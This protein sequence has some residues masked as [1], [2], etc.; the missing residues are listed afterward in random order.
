MDGAW[1]WGLLG[2]LLIGT[3]SAMHLLLNGRIAGT[4]GMLGATLRLQ[5]DETGRLSLA[6]LLGAFGAALGVSALLWRPEI[7]VTTS[8]PALILSGLMVGVG[9]SFSNGCTSGHGVCGMS[10]LSPRSIAATLTFMAATAA[11]VL[12]TR[13]VMGVAP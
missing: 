12:L 4:S 6:F 11:M 3:A 2:G 7:V 9:V 13:H 8:L 1:L 5:G 10:R